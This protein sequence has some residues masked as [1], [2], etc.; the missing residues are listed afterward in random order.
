MTTETSPAPA[1]V[2]EEWRNTGAGLCVLTK[3]SR[4]GVEIDEPLKGGRSI[5]VTSAERRSHQG[6]CTVPQ[7]PY[8]NGLLEPMNDEAIDAYQEIAGRGGLD[9]ENPWSGTQNPPGR[10]EPVQGT[11][12]DVPPSDVERLDGRIDA[13]DDKLDRMLRMLSGE[14][15]PEP[16]PPAAAPASQGVSGGASAGPEYLV[17]DDDGQGAS[18]RSASAGTPAR[19][20]HNKV[21]AAEI[22]TI[23]NGDRAAAVAILERIDSAVV[24]EQVRAK[25]REGHATTIRLGL[26]T[27]YLQRYDPQA[28]PIRETGR[29]AAD[30]RTDGPV[31]EIDLEN[32]GR[33]EGKTRGVPSGDGGPQRTGIP[34]DIV[35]DSSARFAPEGIRPG[36]PLP[37]VPDGLIDID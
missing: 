15:E 14:P 30:E 32:L 23:T 2:L 27:E 36:M 26:I 4:D 24:L 1:A 16:A 5:F 35:D 13:M 9:A 25:A 18:M 33:F 11:R 10:R 22:E 37:Q 21:S 29:I 17:V 28:R 31:D 34:G 12:V 3:H 19:T 6:K 8:R 20:H 7:D